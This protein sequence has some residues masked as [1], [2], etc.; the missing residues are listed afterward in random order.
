MPFQNLF[1]K[2]KFQIV[3]F[4]FLI[5]LIVAGFVAMAVQLKN[6]SNQPLLPVSEIVVSVQI[7]GDPE[8]YIL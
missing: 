1:K 5:I 7:K 6:G 2:Q 4:L 3:A 8:P